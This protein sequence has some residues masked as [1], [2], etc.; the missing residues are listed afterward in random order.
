MTIKP[1]RAPLTSLALAVGLALTLFFGGAGAAGSVKA[2][3]DKA[4]MCEP[5]HGLD[6]RSRLPEAP[7]LAGQIEAYLSEQLNAF[8]T[9]E[10]KNEQM[11]L[12]AKALT[13][14]EIQDLAAYYSGIEITVGKLPAP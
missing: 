4:Q 10:R 6:G 12:I 3:R 8:K 1:S 2:G 13:T 5:C 14:Q 9:G 7:N 11:A